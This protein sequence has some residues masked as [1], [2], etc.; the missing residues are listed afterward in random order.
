MISFTTALPVPLR[1]SRPAP[2]TM[3]RRLVWARCFSAA[4]AAKVKTSAGSQ[5]CRQRCISEKKDV[6]RLLEWS[7]NS[8]LRHDRVISARI[9]FKHF[10]PLLVWEI[11]GNLRRFACI[12]YFSS[13]HF[14]TV[15]R[16]KYCKWEFLSTNDAKS[17][18][19]FSHPWVYTSPTYLAMN[20]DVIATS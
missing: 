18:R 17:L 6:M 5:A 16:T 9:R 2:K 13:L 10:K 1:R 4:G 3:R 15:T 14:S 8:T 11:S 19:G 7:D 20:V 12:Y